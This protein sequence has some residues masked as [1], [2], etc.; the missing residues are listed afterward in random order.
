MRCTYF[1]MFLCLFAALPAM[2]DVSLPALFSDNM[3]LQRGIPDPV[4][5]KADPGEQ[6]S[7]SFC[8]QQVMTTTNIEGRWKVTLAPQQAGGPFDLTVTGKNVIALKN[9]MVGEVWFCSGQSNMAITITSVQNASQEIAAANYPDIRYFSVGNAVAYEPK[10]DCIGTWS[11]TSPQVVSR[12]SAVAYFYGRELSKTLKVPIGLIQSSWSGTPVQSWIDRQSFLENPTLKPS[13][14]N[15]DQSMQGYCKATETAMR[16]WLTAVDRAKAADKPFPEPPTVPNDP[17]SAYA[18]ATGL[19]NGM[20]APLIPYGIAGAIWYQGESNAGQAAL[21]RTLFPALITGWRRAWGQGDFPFYY[22]QVA[23]YAAQQTIP[24]EVSAWAELREAQMQALALPNTGMATTIDIGDGDSIHPRNKQDVG[25][26]L[27]LWAE[28]KTYGMQDVVYSG[29]LFDGISVEGNKIRLRFKYTD[30][31][32]LTK[33]GGPVKGFAIAGVN[34]KFVWADAVI[35][36]DSIL[37]SSTLVPVPAIVR[38]AWGN[39]PV[40]NLYN[41]AGLP[42]VPFRADVPK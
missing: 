42:A 20:V 32:L 34:S 2:A 5:G 33:D 41:K 14:V 3:V 40:C 36:G 30:G 26:R 9:V 25:K 31:G 16:E 11:V 13:I 15:M 6:V 37:V 35:D 8:G 24:G 12:Y 19:Y 1:F 17:R 21:Y 23:N 10:P 38:Y 29:P 27:A 22:V 18:M 39:N 28:A 4:W 7:V